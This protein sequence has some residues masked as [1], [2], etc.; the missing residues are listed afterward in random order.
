MYDETKDE[1]KAQGWT[2][3]VL[4][5]NGNGKRDAYVEPDQPI[6]PT[7]DKRINAPFYGV[8][9]SPVDGL[10]LGIGDRA[11]RGRSSASRPVRTRRRPRWRKSTRCRGTTAKRRS[12]RLRRAAWTSTATA[13]CGP[14]LSS[15]HLASFDRRKCKGPLNGPTATGQH[16]PE[17]WTLYPLPGP[18]YK[19]ATRFGQRRHRL[20]RLRRSLRHARPGGKNVPLA[21]GNGSEA[22][23][24]LV[25]AVADVPRAVS[26]GLLREG[27][28]W[29]HRR[30][31]RRLEG[32]GDLIDL[33]DARAVPH[34]RRQGDDEQA[35]EVP[36]A[37]EPVG[38][39]R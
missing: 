32:Q 35:G 4:D 16:C 27:L 26:D 21:T 9:P 36:G 14:V 15:G 30:S 22:L 1:Q 7:K 17:G 13:S 23:L 2:A 19:G 10:G 6:D 34:R 24:A 38:S 39:C 25:T 11:S 18:N 37:P 28:R 33:R 20:L 8:A 3:F 5:T 29:P 31:E 12:R